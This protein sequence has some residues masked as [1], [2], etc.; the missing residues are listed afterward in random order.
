MLNQDTKEADSEILC[1]S[2][3]ASSG[4]TGILFQ[5]VLAAKVAS[6]NQCDLKAATA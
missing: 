5:M 2:L 1:S 3:S 4:R 6:K